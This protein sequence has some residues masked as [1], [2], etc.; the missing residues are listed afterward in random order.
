MHHSWLGAI[1][2]DCDD[3]GAGERFWTAALGRAVSGRDETFVW[4]ETPPGALLIGLQRVPEP[5]TCKSRVHLDILT[6]DLD[7]EVDRL[8]SL[9]AT[10]E[11]R[12]WDTLWIMH[13]P[14]GNEFCVLRAGESGIPDGARA[15][16]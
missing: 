10:R 4:L 3:I 16:E 6:D 15:W 12:P 8:E 2:I 1:I 11:R 5:K 7:T 9:G 13:D 14:C